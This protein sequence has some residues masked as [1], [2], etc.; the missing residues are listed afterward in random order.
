MHYSGSSAVGYLR[1]TLV[2]FALVKYEE[3][4]LTSMHSCTG[5]EL[6]ENIVR[7]N[8]EKKGNWRK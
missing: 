1:A 3:E 8:N 7:E 4:R 6:E 5:V 2:L